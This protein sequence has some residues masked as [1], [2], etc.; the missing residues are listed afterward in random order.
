MSY[1]GLIFTSSS[2]TIG[3]LDQKLRPD[4]HAERMIL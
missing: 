4:V 3:K 2:V 1:N